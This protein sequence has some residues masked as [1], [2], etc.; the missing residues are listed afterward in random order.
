MNYYQTL[1]VDSL[2]TQ[3]EIK[4]SY[5]R[6]AKRFHPDSLSQT[7]DH[8][9]II[10]INAA[11]EVLSNPQ[12][13]RQYDRELESISLDD[14]SSHRQA[15]TT[16][17]Q[18][19]YRR[20][21]QAERNEELHYYQWLKEVYIPINRLVKEIIN[22]LDREIEYLAAD[23][24]D[25][26]LMENFQAYLESCNRYYQIAQQK[27]VSLPNPTQLAGVAAHIYY[28]LNQISDGIK[29]LEWFTLNYDDRHLHMGQEIFRIA[30]ELR[31][32]AEEKIKSVV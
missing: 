4:Q 2:A 18:Q 17:A 12:T 22:S 6:L 8:N 11:Y 5:R 21:R 23:P 26:Q 28:C 30:Q 9:K 13:R 25:D 3:Q 1:Q 32:Q 24:F 20:Y 29:E 7:A 16:Q 10:E 19:Q 27:F 15:R 14:W 31:Y